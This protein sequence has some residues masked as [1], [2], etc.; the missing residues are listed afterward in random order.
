MVRALCYLGLG[1]LVASACVRRPLQPAVRAAELEPTASPDQVRP[2]PTRREI[3]P[4]TAAELELNELAIKVGAR[5][6]PVENPCVEGDDDNCARRALDR[7]FVRLDTLVDAPRKSVR[8]LH[9]GDS[10][11]A[12]D[13]IT[14]TIRERLQARFGDGGRG[15]VAIEQRAQYG[16][17][18]TDRKGPWQRQRIVDKDQAGQP[19]G[20]AAMSLESRGPSARVAYALEDDDRVTLF[21]LAHPDG[22]EL[23]LEV[24]STLVGRVS[25]ADSGRRSDYKT[26]AIPRRSPASG[27][28][29]RILGI[30]AKNRGAKLFGLSFTR[31][32][33]GLLYDAI[34]PVGADARVWLSLERNSFVE[35]TRIL[36]P[37]LVVLMLG[38]ND[39]LRV[40]QRSS[41][42]EQ[43]RFEME[44]LVKVVQKT[45]PEA[46]CMIW[47]PMDAGEMS[48]G[49]IV[50]KTL[51]AEMRTLQRDVAYRMGCAFWDMFAAM[52]GEG[53]IAR[54][55]K[56]DIINKDLVHPRRRAGE[57]LG[58]LFA[59]AIL[60]A[61]DQLE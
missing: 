42:M 43:I 36:G 53:S 48:G 14:G 41:T 17:R 37:D 58:H 12:A 24:D 20:F 8:I 11:I 56:H 23:E 2:T 28:D 25:T 27:P 35:H 19:F 31:N 33:E 47:S 9:L 16:G 22:P 39:A 54:W 57:L 4:P 7:F 50:S 29:P 38:G 18:R 13:Y 55:S 6:A 60:D 59:N 30:T 32:R 49:K 34:G 44:E 51:V 1:A 15:F 45:V 61:Y 10:H 46:D 21:Y 52:G 3:P 5:R 26:F 40:R